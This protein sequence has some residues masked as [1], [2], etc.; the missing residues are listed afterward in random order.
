MG[1]GLATTIVVPCHARMSASRTRAARNIVSTW[2][3]YSYSAF[4]LASTACRLS[5]ST[6]SALMMTWAA[7]S[8]LMTCASVEGSGVSLVTQASAH[9]V[10][11]V[12]SLIGDLNWVNTLLLMGF[13]FFGAIFLPPH[14]SLQESA[15][16]GC[17]LAFLSSHIPRVGP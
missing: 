14:A 16:D 10:H 2:D 3:A 8:E 6:S 9:A 11:R 17:L 4:S 13:H 12:V 5:A 15:L 1:A 7:P